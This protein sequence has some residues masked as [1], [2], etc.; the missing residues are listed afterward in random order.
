MHMRCDGREGGVVL[1]IGI[2]FKINVH[3]VF[4][5]ATHDG[6]RLDL[7]QVAPF[8][9]KDGEDAGQAA[10]HMGNVECQRCLVRWGRRSVER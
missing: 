10:A 6:E 7:G 4:P 9:G 3:I 5:F 2:E 8:F 1:F